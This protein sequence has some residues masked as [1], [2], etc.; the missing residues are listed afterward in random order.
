[1]K[2]K[3]FSCGY[4]PELTP[5]LMQRTVIPELL[6][7][8]LGTP[9]E[10]ARSLV[11]LRHIN[12][13]FG[14]M[15]TTSDLLRRVARST[16]RRKLSLLEVGAGAGDVPLTAQRVLAGQGLGVAVT[17]LDRIW[18]H[19]PRDGTAAVAGDALHLPFR[20]ETFDVVSCSLL[21][22][23]FEPQVLVEFAR[24]SLRVSR[25]AV[26]LN[27]LIRSRL[28]LFLV[29]LGLPLFRSRMTWHDAPASVRRAYTCP[30]MRD[31]L[32]DAGARKVQISR[33]FLFRMGVLLWK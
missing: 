1:L 5:G 6:D 18:S 2:A 23:H 16:G 32:A 27:D 24:E 26:L 15:R 4:R 25:H 7:E 12:Q 10:I 9:A 20:N 31:M 33:H 11:D 19:L 29:N 22:H 30:E 28:H 8:D 14:G 21:V 13:W 3:Q 17:L